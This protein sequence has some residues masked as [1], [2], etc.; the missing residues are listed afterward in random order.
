MSE[1]RRSLVQSL[2]SKGKV[3]RDDSI[4]DGDDID[5]DETDGDDTDADATVGAE[6]DGGLGACTVGACGSACAHAPGV[7]TA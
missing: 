4:N 5:A 6:A 7:P 1:R 3:T 2:Y